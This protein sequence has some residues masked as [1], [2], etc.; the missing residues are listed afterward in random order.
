MKCPSCS[1]EYVE[2]IIAREFENLAD[3]ALRQGQHWQEHPLAGIAIQSAIGK[4]N[5]MQAL[6][7]LLTFTYDQNRQG[8]G[9]CYKCLSCQQRFVMCY[10]C[11]STSPVLWFP[12]SMKSKGVPIVQ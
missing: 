11:Q 6:T 3:T 9:S 10:H 2:Q 1:H 8:R 4:R 5:G 12:S 7:K